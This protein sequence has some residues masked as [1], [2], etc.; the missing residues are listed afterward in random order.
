MSHHTVIVASVSLFSLPQRRH[1]K[2]NN[3]AVK[4]KAQRHPRSSLFFCALFLLCFAVYAC[5]GA[6]MCAF[7]CVHAVSGEQSCGCGE[8]LKEGRAE[9]FTLGG[10]AW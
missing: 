3:V 4:N 9:D 5:D 7:T 1:A 10:V 2:Q 8:P 6:R